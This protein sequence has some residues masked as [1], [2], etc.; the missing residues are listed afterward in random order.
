[1]TLT[2][3]LIDSI[4]EDC[5]SNITETGYKDKATGEAID[6]FMEMAAKADMA[7]RFRREMAAEAPVQTAIHAA[8]AAGYAIGLAAAANVKEK[9]NVG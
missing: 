9:E 6:A 3:Q 1:M 2:P 5:M 7:K 8:M 4:L